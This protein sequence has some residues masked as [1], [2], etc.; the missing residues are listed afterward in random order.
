M[1]LDLDKI[2]DLALESYSLTSLYKKYF[3]TG[4]PNSRTRQ[5]FKDY[6]SENNV[7]ISHFTRN[8]TKPIYK[9]IEKICPICETTFVTKNDS[10]ES[11]TCSYAC[12]NSY[13]RAGE[14]HPNYKGTHY[15]QI[16]FSHHSKECIVCGESNIV[17]VHHYDENKENNSPDNLIPLCPTHHQYWH[18]RYKYLVKDEVDEYRKRWLYSSQ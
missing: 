9:E 8:G 2:R 12:S 13:F 18:S 1:N 14:D 7:D 4:T 6:L 5:K 15:R 3:K 17:E 10:R 16:C 11:T